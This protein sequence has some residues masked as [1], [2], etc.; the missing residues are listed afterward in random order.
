MNLKFNP[1]FVGVLSLITCLTGAIGLANARNAIALSKNPNSVVAQESTSR[2]TLPPPGLR[3]IDLT[4]QQQEQIQQIW[5][6]LQPQFQVARPTPPQLTEEQKA[7]I[8]Q[9]MQPFRQKLE[10]VL[11]PQQRQQLQEKMK[12]PTDRPTPPFGAPLPP[13]PVMASLNLTAQQ[14]EQIKQI[15]QELRSQMQAILPPPPELTAQQKANLQ[16]LEQSYRQ[17]VEAI[18]QPQQ[19]QP[20]RQNLEQFHQRK[21][22]NSPQGR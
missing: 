14:Q 2:P 22:G 9:V 18:L 7:R 21:L 12:T 15:S 5:S 20:F 19:Q 13:P 3:G 11:S 4:Q 6:E 8:Q 10:A 1:I 17:K 16:R